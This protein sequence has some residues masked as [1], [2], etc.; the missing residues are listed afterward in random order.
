M[1]VHVCVGTGTVHQYI[2]LQCTVRI[3]EWQRARFNVS[4][5]LARTNGVKRLNCW[6]VEFEPPCQLQVRL[7]SWFWLTFDTKGRSVEC[8]RSFLPRNPIK[9]DWTASRLTP[10]RVVVISGHPFILRVAVHNSLEYRFVT[11][12]HGTGTP[13]WKT[14]LRFPFLTS[15]SND[16]YLF[17]YCLCVVVQV[18]NSCNIIAFYSKI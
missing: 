9:V 3:E 5:L 10:V 15:N 17:F 14:H 12:Q 13:T 16:Y 2:R 4:T 18:W 11:V 6:I 8:S 1:Y 7:F